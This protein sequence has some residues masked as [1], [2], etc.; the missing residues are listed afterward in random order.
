LL[1]FGTER[2]VGVEG[3]RLFDQDVSKIRKQ[4]PVALFVRI[5]QRAASGGLANAA[6]LE[7]GA[8][9]SQT[10]FDVAQALAVG[11]L[12][13][14]QDQEVL[15]RGQRTDPMVAPIAADTLVEFVLGQFVHQLG[16][17]RSAFVH[18]RFFPRMRRR[19]TCG[20]AARKGNRK[21]S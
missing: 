15:V 2:F 19:R 6:V 3:G 8:Q 13:E 7:F 14:S 5:R 9:G 11:Q 16:E 10:G 21:K 1:E 18:N 4:P 17:H 20:R 12:G